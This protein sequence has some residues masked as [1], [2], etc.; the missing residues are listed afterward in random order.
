MLNQRPF[1]MAEIGWVW[2]TGFIPPIFPKMV[3]PKQAF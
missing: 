2:S 1:T 3:Y